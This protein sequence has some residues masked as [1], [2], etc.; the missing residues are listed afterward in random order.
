MA[1]L[2]IGLWVAANT[3][4]IF[5]AFTKDNPA[6]V[7]AVL[8]FA[9]VLSIVAFAKRFGESTTYTIYVLTFFG[10]IGVL[11]TSLEKLD[12]LKLTPGSILTL[13][14]LPLAALGPYITRKAQVDV[15]I[16][17][18]A[19]YKFVWGA[20][21]IVP[22]VPFMTSDYSLSIK[23]VLIFLGVATIAPFGHLLYGYSQHQTSY[24]ANVL[25]SN[26]HTPVTAFFTF[27]ILGR[28]L[29]THQLIGI[30]LTMVIVIAVTL[31]Q[32]RNNDAQYVQVV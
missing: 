9:Q 7:I 30:V 19:L 26:S 16:T 2:P 17:K 8:S 27:V 32:Q 3:F 20:I 18:V 11:L 14:C 25:I 13:I 28:T 15:E 29:V 5:L 24:I 22:I 21:F 1:M 12:S 23:D 31:L 4:L 6:N 10:V